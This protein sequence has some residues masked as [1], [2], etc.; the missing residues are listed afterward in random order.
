MATF[1]IGF[2]IKAV[3]QK[4]SYN[5]SEIKLDGPSFDKSIKYTIIDGMP[6]IYD[7]EF[8]AAATTVSYRNAKPYVDKCM[9]NHYDK[10]EVDEVVK[11]TQTF[12][13][14]YRKGGGRPVNV[15]PVALVRKYGNIIE[16]AESKMIKERVVGLIEKEFPNSVCNYTTES[17]NENDPAP[18]RAMGA[19]SV[20]QN[21]VAPR[22]VLSELIP[23]QS[24]VT[25][26]LDAE[27]GS[28]DRNGNRVVSLS[29]I[30]ID[31][32]VRYVKDGE[33]WMLAEID[34]VMAITQSDNNRAGVAS[35]MCYGM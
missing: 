34:I 25:E 27:I 17:D 18:I 16:Q 11:A 21:T 22:E 28:V 14:R 6:M 19:A 24:E 9:R 7:N 8:V 23:V 33:N 10:A 20:E 13:F 29:S 5:N 4:D 1:P 12:L 2:K 30:G 3:L 31:Q 15:I 26:E 35:I 32:E